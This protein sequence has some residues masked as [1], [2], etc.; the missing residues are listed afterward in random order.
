MAQEQNFGKVNVAYTELNEADQT[1]V[2]EIANNAMKS[3]EKS[4][5]TVHYKDVAQLVKQDLDNQK[6]GTWNVVVGRSYGS[7]VTHETKTMTQF[8]IGNIAFLIWKHG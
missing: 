8:F 1:M 2:I 5:K 6:G 4:E 7:F 3:L